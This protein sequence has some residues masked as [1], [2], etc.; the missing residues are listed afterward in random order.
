MFDEPRK[1]LNPNPAG[2]GGIAM[3]SGNMLSES[4][5][6]WSHPWGFGQNQTDAFKLWY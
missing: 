3:K 4:R 1:D 6:P 5:G 2:V